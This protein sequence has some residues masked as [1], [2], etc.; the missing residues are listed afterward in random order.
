MLIKTFTRSFLCLLAFNVSSTNAAAAVQDTEKA[1][2]EDL[3][4]IVVEHGT[5]LLPDNILGSMQ[6]QLPVYGCFQSLKVSKLVRCNIPNGQLSDFESDVVFYAIADKLG[7]EVSQP[8]TIRVPEAV[9][10]C[11]RVVY[12][13]AT[14]EC[15]IER[16]PTVG[17]GN[18]SI[19]GGKTSN[20][21]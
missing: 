11:S 21:L 4:N 19:G 12:P 1:H 8:D 9:I 2:Y 7:S 20:D 17:G 3:F 15:A 13:G 10:T 5:S 6:Y 18:I 16:T 14:A